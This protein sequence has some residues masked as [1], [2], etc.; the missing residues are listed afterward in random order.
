M[1]R[2]LSTAVDALFGCSGVTPVQRSPLAMNARRFLVT[3]PE[4]DLYADRKDLP[5]QVLAGNRLE[6]STC[7]LHIGGACFSCRPELQPV[8]NFILANV[9]PPLL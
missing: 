9:P 2:L 8:L 7:A 3:Y 4:R 5:K 1:R 6:M